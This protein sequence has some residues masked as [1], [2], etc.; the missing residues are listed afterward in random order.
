[1]DD[2][3]DQLP[4]A[5]ANPHRHPDRPATSASACPH[6]DNARPAVVAVLAGGSGSRI[7]GGK[8]CVELGGRPLIE[9]P[10]VAAAAAGL[11]VVVVAKPG[12][13]LPALSVTVIR[14]PA[15]PRHPLC[16][17]VAALRE[18]RAPLV[19]VGCDMPFLT[20]ELLARMA[21]PAAAPVVVELKGTPQ[22]L[23]V[24]CMP[25]QLP[26]LED[27]MARS[28]SLR[29]AFASL[30]PSVVC[31]RELWALGDPRQ[32]LFSVNDRDDLQT[33]KCW[34]QTPQRCRAIAPP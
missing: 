32:L 16:G 5:P 21:R 14:E 4:A 25:E 6:P 27:A 30:S 28:L 31:E 29:A 24:H 19:A 7:G 20:Q 13:T 34:L 17:I 8:P 10:L 3:R 9:Y 18:T 26:Q 1:M 33:A 12:S 11:P 15:E 23:P 2:E 22:P